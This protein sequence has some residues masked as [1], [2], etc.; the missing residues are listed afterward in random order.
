MT[1]SLKVKFVSGVMT[2]ELDGAP[3]STVNGVVIRSTGISVD[4]TVVS[5]SLNIDLTSQE[6]EIE[7]VIPDSLYEALK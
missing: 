2:T 6:G 3:C 4:C 1:H 5:N 7:F